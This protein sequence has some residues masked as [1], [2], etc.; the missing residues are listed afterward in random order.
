MNKVLIVGINPSSGKPRKHS[1]INKLEKWVNELEVLHYGFANVIPEPGEYNINKVDASY[2]KSFC[3]GHEHIVALGGF[4]SQVL[5]KIGVE[6]HTMPHP[7]PLNRKLNDKSYEK[8]C[9]DECK[10]Y[11]NENKNSDN[12]IRLC[13]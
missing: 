5:N 10:K 13:R 2:V 1:A 8:Q 4:V 7:S 12:R 9:I 3:E 11:L 6:H